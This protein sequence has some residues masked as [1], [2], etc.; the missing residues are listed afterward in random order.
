MF[1]QERNTSMQEVQGRDIGWLDLV[2]AIPA[3]SSAALPA[4][5]GGRY[6]RW[7]FVPLAVGVSR[8]RP[9]SGWPESYLVAPSLLSSPDST[10]PD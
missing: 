9:E 4:H 3:G 6:Y 5:C 1:E 7:V 2:S 8:G 10:R